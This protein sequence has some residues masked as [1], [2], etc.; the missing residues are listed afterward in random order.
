MLTAMGR[1]SLSTRLA[2]LP[3]KIEHILIDVII[4]LPDKK[5]K[6]FAKA[7]P[8]LKKFLR[9]TARM[10]TGDAMS[11]GGLSWPTHA[12]LVVDEQNLRDHGEILRSEFFC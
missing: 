11:C 9:Q 12:R 10:L 3:T 2:E 4:L 7:R 8:N 5:R 6:V 1:S